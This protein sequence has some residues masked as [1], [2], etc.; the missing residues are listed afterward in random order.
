MMVLLSGKMC[1]VFLDKCVVVLVV[2]SSTVVVNA[3]RFIIAATTT[4]TEELPVL[5]LVVLGISICAFRLVITATT[6][7]TASVTV[8]GKMAG[9][10][11]DKSVVVVV[12]ISST[13]V[14][15]AFRIAVEQLAGV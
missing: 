3:F 4:V 10:F 15:D 6:T 2:I 8:T 13:L 9:V 12:G 1:G 7:A 5:V 11:L 14:V